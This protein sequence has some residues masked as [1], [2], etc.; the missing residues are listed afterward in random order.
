MEFKANQIE[1][2]RFAPP[3]VALLDFASYQKEALVTASMGKGRA[4]EGFVRVCGLVGEAGEL[5]EELCRWLQPEGNRTAIK[6]ALTKELG[7]VMWYGA[8]LAEWLGVTL[9]FDFATLQETAGRM[10]FNDAAKDVILVRA[11]KLAEILKKHLGHDK[12]MDA[13][14]G[15]EVELILDVWTA[16]AHIAN[17]VGLDLT[18]VAAENVRKLR[19]RH[20]GGGF[21]AAAQNAKA[22]EALTP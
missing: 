6:D 17:T 14:K 21:T 11:S 4:M 13:F 1:E 22:D 18:Y 8:T 20:H 16:I 19:A 12:P 3:L 2:V 9:A 15:R 5:H 7:D 10:V